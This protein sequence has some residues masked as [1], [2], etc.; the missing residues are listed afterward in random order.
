[1]LLLIFHNLTKRKIYKGIDI[2]GDE[3]SKKKKKN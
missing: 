2:V 3:M 1:M